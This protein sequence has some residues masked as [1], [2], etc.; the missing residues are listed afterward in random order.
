MLGLPNALIC[1]PAGGSTAGRWLAAIRLQQGFQ[2]G[3]RLLP[4]TELDGLQAGR[5]GAG[6]IRREIVYEDRFLGRHLQAFERQL[7][8]ARI[9]L[10]QANLG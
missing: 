10:G 2:F 4:G 1:N 3:E 6:H 9:W 7:V 5:L 8:D